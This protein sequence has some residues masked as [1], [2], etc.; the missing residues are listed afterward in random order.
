MLA[1]K[2][3]KKIVLLLPV[4]HSSPVNDTSGNGK[5][6]VGNYYNKTKGRVNAFDQMCF[7]YSCSRKTNQWPLC[8]FFG[9]VNASTVNA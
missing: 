6:E 9:I 4:M 2:T 7:M 5:L 3:T 1:K 8:L